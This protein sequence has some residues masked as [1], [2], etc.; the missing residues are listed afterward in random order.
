[1]QKSIDAW[2]AGTRLAHVKVIDNQPITTNQGDKTMSEIKEY[3]FYD[4][5]GHIVAKVRTTSPVSFMMNLCALG[6]QVVDYKESSEIPA[7]SS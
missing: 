1:M 7:K 4:S 6:V 2:M 5:Q 3:E